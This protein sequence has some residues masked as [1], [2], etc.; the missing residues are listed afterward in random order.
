M[1]TNA[2]TLCWWE[3][4][5]AVAGLVVGAVV[6]PTTIM[7]ERKGAAWFVAVLFA[8][9]SIVAVFCFWRLWDV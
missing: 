2:T 9:F 6:L 1:T 7:E 5:V 4:V 3:L 8:M